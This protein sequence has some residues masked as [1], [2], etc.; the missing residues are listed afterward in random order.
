M[1]TGS[2]LNPINCFEGYIERGIDADRYVGPAE[3]VI[4][5]RRDSYHRKTCGRQSCRA[6]LGPVLTDHHE[7][8][9][10]ASSKLFLRVFQLLSFS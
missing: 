6:G 1:R 3:I 2:D 4:D 7:P 8:F 10:S 9:D 5:S